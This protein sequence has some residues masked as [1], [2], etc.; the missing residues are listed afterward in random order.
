MIRIPG[1]RCDPG[2]PGALQTLNLRAGPCYDGND[3]LIKT[4]FC[5]PM[6]IPQRGFSI[7]DADE[8]GLFE[9]F[10]AVLLEFGVELVDKDAGI[11][12]ALSMGNKTSANVRIQNRFKIVQIA[13]QHDL[14]GAFLS[15]NIGPAYLVVTK[16]LQR[17]SGHVGVQKPIAATSYENPTRR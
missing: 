10:D 9:N 14:S 16:N 6:S 3:G 5:F 2:G 11:N 8:F 1:S 7:F 15:E 17:V 12:V 4:E 13:V